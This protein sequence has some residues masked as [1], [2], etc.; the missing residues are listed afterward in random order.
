MITLITARIRSKQPDIELLKKMELFC[1]T[2]STWKTKTGPVLFVPRAVSSRFYTLIHY[3]AKPLIKRNKIKGAVLSLGFPYRPYFFSKT[4]PYFTRDADMRVL[5]TY[6]VWQPDYSRVE[7]IVREGKVNLLLLSS[8]QA[9]EHFSR[10][11]IPDCT[12]EWVPETINVSHYKQKPWNE[13]NIDILSF[14][15]GWREYHDK[16]VEGCKENKI[17]YVW[18]RSSEDHDVAVHGLKKDLLFPEWT[19]FIAGLA[20]TQICICFPRSITHPQLAGNVSTLTIR[21]LQAMASKCLILGAAPLDIHYL[22]DYNPVVEVDWN[23][24][25][26]QIRNILAHPAKWQA[27]IEKNYETVSNLFHHRNAVQQIDK[28]ICSQLENEREEF[29]NHAAYKK[30]SL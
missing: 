5:W 9:T 4:F 30:I 3:L 1:K 21:Y 22:L 25:A 19:D 28:L 17:N 20:N 23:D 10:L 26:G 12:V 11:K 13:R 8:H 27:L 15:R 16:I 7:R 2:H 24:P 29:L 14:G 18:Q 6:D